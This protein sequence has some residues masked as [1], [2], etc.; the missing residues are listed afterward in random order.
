MRLD[1]EWA[2]E[3]PRRNPEFL[4]D[5]EPL[6]A[7]AWR[8]RVDVA[9]L[10]LELGFGVDVVDKTDQRPLHNA[11]ASGSLELLKLLVAHGADV[12]RP[13]TQYGGPLGLASHFQQR[14]IAAFLAPLSR[15]V[16]NLTYLGFKE[17]LAELFAADP[18][19]LNAVHFRMGC[20]PLFVL[21]TRR[22][23]W[24]RSFCRTA[25]IRP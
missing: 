3:L 8:G 16:H 11:V 1:R 10:L 13:T 24:R 9:T 17:R 22:S 14:E 25:Q 6:L 4:S 23:R 18:T 5:G 19:L 21:P 20:T 15:D 7:A 12:D 2:P